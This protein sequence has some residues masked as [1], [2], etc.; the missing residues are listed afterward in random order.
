M[1][2]PLFILRKDGKWVSAEIDH[3]KYGQ[4]YKLL[5]SYLDESEGKGKIITKKVSIL[6]EFTLEHLKIK[7]NHIESHRACTILCCTQYDEETDGLRF[8][9][10]GTKYNEDADYGIGVTLDTITPD[11][12]LSKCTLPNDNISTFLD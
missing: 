2:S 11:Y 10:Y 12:I 4:V 5:K 8:L 1:S 3:P 6:P 9:A 7:I